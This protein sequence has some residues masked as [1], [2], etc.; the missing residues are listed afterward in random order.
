MCNGVDAKKWNGTTASGWGIAG[1]VTAPTLSFS[2]GSLSPTAGYKYVFSFKNS[3]TGLPSTA[4]DPSANTGPQ[5]NRNIQ[6]GGARST[7]PQADTI[8]IY[9]NK[10]G[11]SVYY[12]LALIANPG[13]GSWSYTDS[14]PD[15]GLNTFKIA[16]INHANDPPPA[17]IRLVT[18]HANRLWVAVGNKVY[19]AAGPDCTNGVPE[20]CF[21]PGNV[22]TFPGAVN[23]MVSTTE[24]L[25]V[26]TSDNAYIIR[27]ADSSSFYSKLWMANFGVV[28]QNCI[29]QD[30]DLIFLYT[31]KKQLFQISDSLEEIGFPVGDHLMTDFPPS[32]TC[33]ALHRS[34]QD[35]GLFISNGTTDIYKYSI[36]TS[37]WSTVIRPVG[38]VGVIASVEV[39]PA[40]FRL[41]VGRPTGN[42]YI[43]NRNVSS[44]QDDGVSYAMYGTVGS[45][46]M[47]PPGETA[48]V[49][50]ILIERAAIGSDATVSVLLNEISG[51]FV[52]LPN[53]VPDPPL[54]PPSN[55]IIAK[56]HY[57]KAATTPLAQS[58]VRHLQIKFSFPAEAVRNELLGLAIGQ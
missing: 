25:L 57:L 40:D 7:D 41:L 23:A 6:L 30:G 49:D 12:F 31:S 55:S 35:S 29:A 16:P 48:S 37:S 3:S 20:E 21:P 53:P 44:S 19:F 39:T 33:L 27:G 47:A 46:V 26:C 18:F 34:G 42:G 58:Q 54:I 11:G 32:S 15:S 17:G 36:T 5:T 13:A 38:G 24:G 50:S 52:P 43:L 4:S 22:F 56:R 9:R 8:E 1:P 28:S 2:V 14:T 51:S 45:L 10:D